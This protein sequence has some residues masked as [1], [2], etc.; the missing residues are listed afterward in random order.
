MT[1]IDYMLKFL[2]MPHIR[3]IYIVISMYECVYIF[4]VSIQSNCIK[5]LPNIHLSPQ[6]IFN[7]LS[8]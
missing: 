1:Y 4:F 7:V 6:M 3:H 5:F 2:S 8:N